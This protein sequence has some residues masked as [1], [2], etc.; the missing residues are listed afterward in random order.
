MKI[1]SMLAQ[2]LRRGAQTFRFPKRPPVTPNYRGLVRFDPSRCTG[3]A[4]CRFRCTA[5]AITFTA[6]KTEFIWSYDP[7]HCTFCGRCVDGC[8]EHA[9]SQESACPPVYSDLGSLK[10]SYT[11]ARKTPAPKAASGAAQQPPETAPGGAS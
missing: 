10:S 3:C 8:K 11:V 2:N 1:L 9:L 5:G 4:M 7:G 6:A